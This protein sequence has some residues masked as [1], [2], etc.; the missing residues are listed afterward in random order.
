VSAYDHYVTDMKPGTWDVPSAGA[1][2][3]TW[4]Y[5]QGRGR[6]LDLYQ[7]GKDKQWDATKR[8]DW[9]I[10]V[11]P[12]NVMEQ[13]EELSPIY[14]SRQWQKL[15]QAE[16]DELGM[17][18]SSW[19]FSQF[20]HGEQGALTVA[21][22]IVE[23]VPEMDSKFYAAT[24]TMDEARHVE[25]Y[26]K[27]IKDKIGIYYPIN[28]NLATL[29]A[30]AL[31][32]GRWDYPYLG[33]QVLIEGLALAAF[34]VHRDMSNNPLVTQLLAYVMQDEARHVAFGRLAL[35]DYYAELTEP[36]R[37]EREEFLI[38]GCYLMN[39]RFRAQEV[40]ET[41]NFDVAECM[42]FTD[43]SPVQQAFR[44]LLFT[45]IVPCVRDIGLWGPKVRH[46]FADLGVLG[47]ADSDLESL[48]RADEDLAERLDEEK[49]QAE[50]AARQAE[51][52]AVISDAADNEA[53]SG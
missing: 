16:R 31:A 48:M 46:A 25:V 51:V 49:Y 4:E 20:L 15:N 40:Y 13:T 37:A 8:I 45:R 43:K 50:F 22:R 3:F 42:D 24:Q 52:D 30:E 41:L 19:L 47:A 18:L 44:S 9:D 12:C 27:F 11:N 23:S 35:R 2:R 28:D 53:M 17:H 7:R 38:E 5:E 10:P 6:L 29:L 34:G 21:A 33:M 32:D 14:G 1:S 39:N 26:S 36:E